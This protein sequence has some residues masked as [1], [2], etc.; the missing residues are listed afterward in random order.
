M[1]HE[2]GGN[3]EEVRVQCMHGLRVLRARSSAATATISQQWQTVCKLV[4]HEPGGN[5]EEVRVQCMHGLRVLRARSS[6]ATANAWAMRG[7]VRN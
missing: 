4:R 3:D 2:P 6:A 5:D 1:R 7:L